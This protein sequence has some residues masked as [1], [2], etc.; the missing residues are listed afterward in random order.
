MP[1]RPAGPEA[2]CWSLGPEHADWPP[3]WREMPLPPARVHGRGARACLGRE[4][5]AVVGTRRA[6]SRGLAVARRIAADL[7]R[8]GWVVVSGLA[9]GIDGAAHAGALEAGGLSVA[10]MGTGLDRTWPPRHGGLRARLEAQGC[11]ITEYGWGE[12]PQDRNFAERNRLVAGLCRGVLVVE[13]PARSGALLTAQISLELDR[14]VFAVPGPVDA[15][16]SR[17]CHT[18]RRAG[19]GLVETAADIHRH[20][21]PP[22][23]ARAPRTQPG[24]LLPLPAP[25]PDP[26]PRRL[27]DL[28]DL[29]GV[30]WERLEAAWEGGAGTLAEALLALELA[31]LIRRLPGGRV[32]RKIWLP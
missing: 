29:E 9:A 22:L 25:G 26:A 8:A 11:V 17:G 23:L 5:I 12:E 27:W 31:G 16:Q 19:A 14:E 28:L 10:V 15:L 21:S 13:A 6:T 7:A 30:P 24:G 3:L 20:L 4:A 2:G 32:A 18:L 1:T